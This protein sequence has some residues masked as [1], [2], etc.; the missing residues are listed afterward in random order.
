MS[1]IIQG[2]QLR[3]LDVGSL[4]SRAAANLPQSTTG[5]IFIVSGGR[6]IVT[7]IVG[8]VTTVIQNQL[9][10]TKLTSSPTVG[11]AV[12]LCAVV[13]I[14]NLEVGGLLSL[15]PAQTATPFSLALDKQLA[16][17]IPLQNTSIIVAA[18]SIVLNCAASN[19]GQIKWD[20]TYLPFDDGASVAAA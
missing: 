12:D 17:A 14:A 3:T 16:G 15:T 1:T 13:D 9:N 2:S 5:N 11:S 20:L 19:T 18:G 8:Q 10:N 4:V 7:S 6:V